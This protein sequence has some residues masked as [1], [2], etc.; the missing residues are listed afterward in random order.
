MKIE[1]AEKEDAEVEAMAAAAAA[2]AAALHQPMAGLKLEGEMVI[3][4]DE[5]MEAWLVDDLSSYL[6]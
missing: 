3:S 4:L 1:K 5:Y 6:V 2:A